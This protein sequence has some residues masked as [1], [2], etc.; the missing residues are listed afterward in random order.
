[1]VSY[2]GIVD[3]TVVPGLS[4]TITYTLADVNLATNTWIF[5]YALDNTST[6]NS[7]VSTF[8]FNT[9]PNILAAQ[10]LSGTVFTNVASGNVPQLGTVDFCL[11]AGPNCAGG[12]GVGVLPGDGIVTGSFSLDFGSHAHCDR[13]HR[14]LRAVS[15]G[16]TD[17]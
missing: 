9:D 15:V 10:V 1:M 7:R 5:N 8:G 4:A 6:I 2:N 14:S 11:T 13:V 12:S 16:R 17:R 3:V